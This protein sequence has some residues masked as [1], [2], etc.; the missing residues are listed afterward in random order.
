MNP[1]KEIKIEKLTLNIGAGTDTEKLKKGMML[2]K[3]MTGIE[4]IK[5]ISEK[6]IPSWGVRP[7]L[8]V[9]CKITLRGKQQ[10]HDLVKRLLK[11][12][13]NT[14]KESCFDDKGNLSFGL[15]EYIDIQDLN[16]DPKIGIMGFQVSITLSRAGYRVKNRKKLTRKVGKTHQVTK[17]E[18]IKYFQENFELKVEE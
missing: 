13:D 11:A 4:P 15:H 10:T 3:N 6:R 9:G 16:Y 8:P 14:L 2:L 5:T 7:G 1:M 12:K 17:E 18:G